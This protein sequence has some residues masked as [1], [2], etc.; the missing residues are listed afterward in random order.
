MANK[1]RRDLREIKSQFPE[2]NRFQTSFS[3]TVHSAADDPNQIAQHTGS[4][5]ALGAAPRP[6]NAEIKAMRFIRQRNAQT[7]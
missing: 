1:R 5:N 7:R 2:K 3:M 4:G 6:L